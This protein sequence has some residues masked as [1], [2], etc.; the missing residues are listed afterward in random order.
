MTVGSGSVTVSPKGLTTEQ[1]N[2]YIQARL[3]VSG[4][5]IG[6][7]PTAADPVSGAPTQ[8]QVMSSLREFILSNPAVINT[9]RPVAVQGTPD[10][11]VLLSQMQSPPLEYPSIAEAWTGRV[12]GA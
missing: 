10:N 5:D 4:I 12:T 6:L 2:A 11:A 1:L 7:F 8:E 3:V 9:W